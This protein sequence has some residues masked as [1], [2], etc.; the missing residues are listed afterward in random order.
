MPCKSRYAAPICLV[1]SISAAC[2]AAAQGLWEDTFFLD[3][4][5]GSERSRAAEGLRRGG[6][7]LS[8]GERVDFRDWY[9]PAFSDTT[10]LLLTQVTPDFGIIWGASTGESAEKYR[11]DP[12][13]H[14]GFVFRYVPFD[15]AEI[16]MKA[17][18]PFFGRLRERSC[19]ADYPNL[20]GVYTVNCRLAAGVLPPEETLQYLVD[21]RGEA[22]AKV[23]IS[24]TLRF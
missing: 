11:I 19:E 23:S 4:Y 18:Y 10:L 8:G 3:A 22:D 1:L 14:L 21:M 15:N 5:T 9:T 13:V 20:G 6:Y 24:F 12:A 17:T 2:P 7:E 16:A